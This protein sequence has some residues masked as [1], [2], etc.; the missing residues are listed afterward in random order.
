MNENMDLDLNEDRG[1][2][3]REP[4]GCE[5]QTH[6]EARVLA[7]EYALQEFAIMIGH[8]VPDAR[9]PIIQWCQDWTDQRNK[10]REAFRTDK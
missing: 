6:W 3:S 9:V 2:P 8:A 4:Q 10:I 1:I 5:P 7:M